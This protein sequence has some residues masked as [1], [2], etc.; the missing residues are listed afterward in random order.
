MQF[1]SQVSRF[2]IILISDKGASHTMYKLVKSFL[3]SNWQYI[4]KVLKTFILS[5]PIILLL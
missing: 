3:K 2:K 1:L 5:Y 4:T